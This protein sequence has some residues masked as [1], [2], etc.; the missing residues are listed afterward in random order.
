M[1]KNAYRDS[2]FYVYIEVTLLELQVVQG[3]FCI[4]KVACMESIDFSNEIMFVAKTP[5]EISLVCESQYAP[6]RAINIDY[7]WRAIRVS[8]ILDFS[9]VGIVS[10]LS[11]VLADAGISIF[12]VSTYDTDYILIKEG[13]FENSLAVLQNEGYTIKDI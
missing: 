2:P 9:L 13:S 8:G 5:D 12:V 7:G 1:R 3:E 6:P 10:K 11:N 4:C